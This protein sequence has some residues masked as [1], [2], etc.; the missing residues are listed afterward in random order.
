MTTLR[1]TVFGAALAGLVIVI[2]AQQPPGETILVD[3][4]DIA[5]AVTV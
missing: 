4:D 3:P 2:T 5:G 1:L